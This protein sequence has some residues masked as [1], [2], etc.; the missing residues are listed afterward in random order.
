M[1]RLVEPVASFAVGSNNP[2]I[3]LTEDLP[4]GVDADILLLGCPDVRH[5][6]YTLYAERGFPARKLDITACD[7]NE[8]V[9]ARNILFLTLV[10]DGSE[11]ISLAQLWNVYYHFYL[12]ETDLQ[13]V[14]TQA[15]KLLSFSQTLKDWNASQYGTTL[16]FC[17]ETTLSVLR[18]VWAKYAD[19]V[20]DR[21]TDAYKN[22]FED[23]LKESRRRRRPLESARRDVARSCAPLSAQIAQNLVEAGEQ[24]WQT[25]LAGSLP[26]GGT[27]GV[28]PN[29]V[30]AV[31]LTRPSVLKYPTD[32]LA[33]F[34]LAA[35]HANLTALSPLRLDEEKIGAADPK[36]KLF[37][38]ARLQFREWIDAFREAAPRVTIR[39]VAADYFTLCYTLRY[40]LETGETCAH[41]YRRK[42]GFDRLDLA[43]CDY[44]AEGNAPKQFD[45]IDTSGI[46]NR[47]SILDL[48]VSAGPL[49]K[50]APPST[51]WTERL[52]RINGGSA[53]EQLLCG[54][55]TTLSILLGLVPV[56]YW[57]N[58]S[59]VS[60]T[61][62]ILATWSDKHGLTEPVE[63]RIQ[64][65]LKWKRS[66]HLLSGPQPQAAK[67]LV[68]SEA[69]ATCVYKICCEPLERDQIEMM[70]ISEG[71][72][73]AASSSGLISQHRQGA[74]AAF[75]AAVCKNLD[76]DP[77]LAGRDLAAKLCLGDEQQLQYNYL[78]TLELEMTD[79]LRPMGL[80]LQD[81]P[82]E[83]S[84]NRRP[85]CKRWTDRAPAIAVTVVIPPDH[86]KQVA[87]GVLHDSRAVSVLMEAHWVIRNKDLRQQDLEAVYSDIQVS[88]GAATPRGSPDDD[89]FTVLVQEDK[90]GWYG[91]SPM[92][93]SFYVSSDSTYIVH[94]GV[95]VTIH[96]AKVISNGG[97]L[98]ES[99]EDIASFQTSVLD[100][101]H[102]FITRHR[103]GQTSYHITEGALRGPGN[104]QSTT[105]AVNLS[106]PDSNFSADFDHNSGDLISVTGHIDITSDKGKQL[107]ADKA[108]I[109]LQQSSP[110]TIDVVFGKKALVLPLTFPIPVVKDGSKTRIARK[111]S[112]IEVI[113]PLGKPLAS[114]FLDDFI[115]PSALIKPPG[116]PA[117][118]NMPHLNLDNL[119]IL[120]LDDKDRIRFITT[121]TSFSFSA[122]ERRLRDE[123]VQE[124]KNGLSS[125][126]RL[127]FKESLFTIF[128]LASGLQGGQTGLFAITHPERG[129]I[130]MLLFVSA[131]RLDGAHGGVVLDAAVLPFTKA[132][133]DS[134]ALEA[135]LLLL[136][137]LECCTLTVDD[138]EL[139]LWKKTLPALAERCRTWSHDPRT[140]EYVLRSEDATV[141]LSLDVGA[142]VLCSCGMGELPPEFVPLPEW[143]TAARYATRVAISPAY[144]SPL[145]EE[146]VDPGLAKSLAEAAAAGGE[147][148]ASLKACRNCGKTEEME[149]VKLKKCLR[150]LEVVYCSS[151][152]QKKDWKKHRMECEEADVYNE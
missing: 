47:T 99:L 104:R 18:D 60:A 123:V 147:G 26:A 48:L 39:F 94:P 44:G 128:M 103:P 14:G 86:W 40:N 109:V 43:D 114:P 149:G 135:F 119:P 106:F 133:V 46:S 49:L 90:D 96:L 129:G 141:P 138:A 20:R 91:T 21:H 50:D 1:P 2:A 17:D 38:M 72:A 111:S 68:N 10:L 42:V 12:D 97:V 110:F 52:Q 113:A 82:S 62:E 139:A 37:E 63:T 125:S 67:M 57:T 3:S 131:I 15:R 31:P 80:F 152:C 51:L 145:V 84:H 79:G 85:F 73:K 140:C 24:H 9:I 132:L 41:W 69:L 5:I 29:P 8:D 54:H 142:Q 27:T 137:T 87:Q 151:E 58:A 61:D 93:V 122:R 28:L 35:A 105:T 136:R 88:F 95:M 127:N 74:L 71:K 75:F 19:A 100:R 107:L 118:L 83:I 6:I 102:V 81:P 22:R 32:P 92:I 70:T 101:K 120:A 108:P 112:Y 7:T 55:T 126:A 115:F 30:F 77:K 150:C 36:L 98:E 66:K 148:K 117:T 65:R 64:S 143:D 56:Q 45:V 4:Q 146:V 25:G 78:P 33:S 144:A 34:H 11:A 59:A 124:T 16:R 130:H 13:L 134:G 53:L 121:L 76:L 89:D 116:I 23:G